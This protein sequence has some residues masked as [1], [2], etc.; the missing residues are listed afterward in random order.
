MDEC[1]VRNYMYFSEDMKK[2]YPK[3]YEKWNANGD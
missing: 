2:I 1:I 3:L